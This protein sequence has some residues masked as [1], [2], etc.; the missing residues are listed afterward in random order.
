MGAEL[1]T[2]FALTLTL[3]H[4]GEGIAVVAGEEGASA[5]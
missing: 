5:S 2:G 4:Q 1:V 3:S